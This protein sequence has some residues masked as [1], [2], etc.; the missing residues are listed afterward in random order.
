MEGSHES[1]EAAPNDRWYVVL[2]LKHDGKPLGST[3]I[4]TEV[5]RELEYRNIIMG[6]LA[7]G[8]DG[9][10]T[11]IFGMNANS[12]SSDGAVA[13]SVETVWTLLEAAGKSADVTALTLG[14]G[15][16]TRIDCLS[17]YEYYDAMRKELFD[18]PDLIS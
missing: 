15:G 1:G 4:N 18:G 17:Q 7:E 11:V 9:K 12:Y 5:A 13:S 3:L 14:I 6:A 16:N 10:T 2:T 8:P